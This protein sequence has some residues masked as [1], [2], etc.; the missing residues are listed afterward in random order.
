MAIKVI[1][2]LHH[3]PQQIIKEYLDP[4]SYLK[5]FP[6]TEYIELDSFP[7]WVGFFKLDWHHQW[8]KYI[9]DASNEFEI[10][11]WRPYGSQITSIY[12]KNIEGIKHKV[13]PSKEFRVK[14]AGSFT[15][16]HLMVKALKSEIKSNKKIIIHF[17][18]AHS[19][20]IYYLIL[21]LRKTN[22]PIIV[23]HL[24]GWFYCF[25]KNNRINPFIWLKY[26]IEKYALHYVSK[27][28]SASRTELEFL[29]KNFKDLDFEFFLNGI[30]IDKFKRVHS[31]SVAKLKLG[32]RED[33]KMILFVGRLDS[34][35]NVDLI[36]KAYVEIKAKISDVVLFL[37]GGYKT[38][39]FYNDAI[40]CG[41]KVIERSDKPINIYYEA[42]DVYVMPV[43]NFFVREF[44]GIGIAP[45]EALALNIPVISG[46]LKHFDGPISEA[47]QV[48]MVL[49]DQNQILK[50]LYE[51]IYDSEKYSNGRDFIIK[52]F[53]IHKNTLKLIR[54]Y[55][56]LLKEN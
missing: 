55:S 52:H 15:Y 6:D 30:D 46:A 1:N 25:E 23:Q 56:S 51:I 12:E 4:L 31:K 34:T 43:S 22:V 14:K 29:K 8:G 3:I 41:A 39:M 7:F 16:S 44:G 13:F 32:L 35:K 21:K 45:L 17:Y 9:R 24:G 36:I 42:A 18:G 5:R 20:F 47:D 33:Q 37:V 19:L 26:S 10:E 54:I 49:H 38:D 48:G 50:S 27:Y 53:D 2:I 40:S 11:C 28:L